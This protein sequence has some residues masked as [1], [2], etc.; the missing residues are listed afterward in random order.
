M[1]FYAAVFFARMYPPNLYPETKSLSDLVAV[2]KV[3]TRIVEET[4]AG[5]VQAINDALTEANG[6]L[7]RD[8]PKVALFTTDDYQRTEFTANGQWKVI[9]FGRMDAS[10]TTDSVSVA[11]SQDTKPQVQFSSPP[12]L[13]PALL[14]VFCGPRPPRQR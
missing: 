3:L 5:G 9:Y 6:L 11:Y 12:P 13:P 4:R 7:A 10:C 8:F 1:T 14:L 2:Q